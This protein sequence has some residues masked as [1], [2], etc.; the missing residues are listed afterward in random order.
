MLGVM[1]AEAS[2]DRV[3]LYAGFGTWSQSYS[4]GAASGGQEID[5]ESDLDLGRSANNVMY[6]ALE[7]PI[8]VL[9]N[10]RLQKSDLSTDGANVLTRDF[11]W[12]G[13]TYTAATAVSTEAKIDQTDLTM[14]YEL[15]DNVFS[16][17][18]GLAAR[19][20]DGSIGIQSEVAAGTA[21]FKGVVPM[22]YG[23]ARVDVPRTGAW[24]A[25]EMQGIGYGGHSLTDTNFH[26]GWESRFG[27]GVEAGWRMY[28]FTLDEIDDIAS[29]DFRVDGPY[30]AL[31]FHF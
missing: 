27:L 22:L 31:N 11:D 19:L 26:A 2:A 28:R 13:A 6:L 1:A 20:V 15:L 21:E 29:A 30:A 23:R 7:H 25:V 8:P 10:L 3:G 24:V 12:R 9:P 16:L 14:Y 4:G 18:L 17:D 5:F